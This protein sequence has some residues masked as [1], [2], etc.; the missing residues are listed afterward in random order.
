MRH[1]NKIVRSLMT[2][3]PRESRLRKAALTFLVAATA[4]FFVCAPA[5]AVPVADDPPVDHPPVEDPVRAIQIV[6]MGQYYPLSSDAIEGEWHTVYVST[7]IPFYQV[8]WYVNGD[9]KDTSTNTPPTSNTDSYFAYE[10]EGLGST[11]GNS[12]TIKAVAI[13]WIPKQISAPKEMTIKVFRN[14]ITG[15]SP[16]LDNVVA[17]E[18]FEATAETTVPF[19][20]V[21][22]FIKRPAWFLAPEAERVFGDPIYVTIGPSRKASFPHFFESDDTDLARSSDAGSQYYIVA[23]VF[24]QHHPNGTPA[25]DRTPIRV[26]EG[27][28]KFLHTIVGDDGRIRSQV[29]MGIHGM[30]IFSADID[31]D[32][33]ANEW[34]CDVFWD[35]SITYY[36][37]TP[38]D[39]AHVYA[40]VKLYQIWDGNDLEIST[41]FTADEAGNRDEA[42]LLWD[43]HLT[44]KHSAY[45][46]VYRTMR[47]DRDTSRP[48]Q[49]VPGREYYLFGETR[50]EDAALDPRNPEINQAHWNPLPGRAENTTETR[51]FKLDGAPDQFWVVGYNSTTSESEEEE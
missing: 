28:D 1:L 24:P 14:E 27:K 30:S 13:G 38:G 17:G 34:G 21:E 35:H 39:K 48:A 41:E 5:G 3:P 46:P 43:L 7:D 6:K 20:R 37:D 33:N 40:Y 2:P 51:E 12:V 9:L 25:E 49:L 42:Q 10:Y 36:N 16:G 15:M 32:G 18:S 44:Y 4:A 22:W 19:D 50:L 45:T 11:A 29:H 31:G 47:D 26:H 23:R 8:K